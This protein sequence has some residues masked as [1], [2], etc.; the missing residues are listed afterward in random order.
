MRASHEIAMGWADLDDLS[1]VANQPERLRARV[2]RV[3][4][5][6]PYYR[7]QRDQERSIAYICDQARQFVGEIKQGDVVVAAD[8]QRILGIGQIADD[9]Y[10]YAPDVDAEAPHRRRVE[11]L[12][13]D[14]WVAPN[15]PGKQRTQGFRTTCW[16]ITDPG[17]IASIRQ[18]L[19]PEKR[20]R[21]A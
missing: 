4:S 18:H 20:V 14:D 19:P 3:R 5:N 21:L 2:V 7:D 1:Q 10:R 6:N 13:L 15:P 9:R 12:S 16:R 17:T 11:W 8:G